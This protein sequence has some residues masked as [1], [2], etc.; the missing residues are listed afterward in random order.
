MRRPGRERRGQRAALGIGVVAQHAGRGH[1]QRRVLVGAV[2]VGGGGGCV[3]HGAHGDGCGGRVAAGGAVVGLVGEGIGAVPV[4]GRRV[5]EGAIGIQRQRAVAGVGNL[6]RR[7]RVA[8][9]V[10]VVGQYARRRHGERGILVGAVGVVAGHGRPVGNRHDGGVDREARGPDAAPR[11]RDVRRGGQIELDRLAID[12]G[13]A[14]VHH[15]EEIHRSA[16]SDSQRSGEGERP[17]LRGGVERGRGRGDVG[18]QARIEGAAAVSVLVD[19]ECDLSVGDGALVAHLQRGHRHGAHVGGEVQALHADAALASPGDGGRGAGAGHAQHR[20]VDLP[21]SQPLPATVGAVDVHHSQV[22]VFRAIVAFLRRDAPVDGER[23][24]GARH[25]GLRAVEIRPAV[26]H[27]RMVGLRRIEGIGSSGDIGP[28]QGVVDAVVGDAHAPTVHGRIIGH[29]EVGDGDVAHAVAI[30]VGGGQG[31]WDQGGADRLDGGHAVVGGHVVVVRDAPGSVLGPAGFHAPDGARPEVDV[32]RG[33]L[34][35]IVGGQAPL[36]GQKAVGARY[37][38]GRAVEGSVRVGDHVGGGRREAPDRR[39][40]GIVVEVQ[41]V[42]RGVVG[43]AKP[44]GSRSAAVDQDRGGGDRAAAG[45]VRVHAGEPLRHARRA[46]DARRRQ[47]G[48]GGRGAQRELGNQDISPRISAGG[49]HVHPLPPGHK[50]EAIAVQRNGTAAVAEGAPQ[51]GAVVQGAAAGAQLGDEGIAVRAAPVGALI[52]VRRHGEVGRFRDARHV[53]AAGGIHRDAV[54]P[55]VAVTALLHVG[56]APQVGGVGEGAAVRADLCHEGVLVIAARELAFPPPPFVHP[57]EGAFGHREVERFRVADHVGAPVR[58]YRDVL[59][60]VIAA[61]AQIR[62][63]EEGGARGVHLRHEPLVV[64]AVHRL[65]R[66]GC[67]GRTAL[68]GHIGAA[69]AIHRDCPSLP[70]AV[71]AQI[72]GVDQGAAACVELG[73]ERDYAPVGQGS[74]IGARR[75]RE[76]VRRG[77]GCAGHVGAAGGIHRDA[78]RCVVGHGAQAGGVDEGAAGGVELRHESVFHRPAGRIEGAGRHREVVRSGHACH[79]GAAAAIQ[80]DAPRLVVAAPPEVGA[81]NQTAAGGIEFGDERVVRP[82]AVGRLARAGPRG[83]VGGLRIAGHVG[84]SLGIHRD[85]GGVIVTVGTATGRGS[86]TE[87]RVV[88]QR[89]VHHQGPAVVVGGQAEERE[90]PICD[91]RF[92]ICTR[93]AR[94]PEP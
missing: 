60:L 9:G 64:T 48:A 43:G 17:R 49:N 66:A 55:V 57:L 1:R 63:V 23:V 34:P 32:L 3:V 72:G 21:R 68:A 10:G 78:V 69:A 13:S 6:H 92:S 61:A 33:T 56:A 14:Y 59:A 18:V 53:G 8:L 44:R 5:G 25:A 15:Q 90:F 62:G 11:D 41:P 85:A 89:G 54:A 37:G 24:A 22:D 2:E 79:V 51:K 36:D 35:G 86:A 31:L 39:G 19:A 30:R 4:G 65:E 93:A 87:V 76:G 27:D 81:V 42:G 77:D 82:P 7:A 50:G 12:R 28:P 46:G 71:P 73:Q 58:V 83:E 16:G 45:R 40:A 84:T 70:A 20:R 38:G 26:E 52:R 91:F 75:H 94:G 88:D 74:L 47:A 67:R 29:K 80:R